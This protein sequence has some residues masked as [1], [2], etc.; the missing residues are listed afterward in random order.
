M[1]IISI[2]III[3]ARGV[4]ENELQIYQEIVKSASNAIFYKDLNSTYLM[5]NEK[6]LE[7]FGRSREEVI[8]KN[9][10]EI[11]CEEEARRNIRDDKIVFKTGKRRTI[12]K[13]MTCPEG[14]PYWF[15]AIKAP[16]YDRKG[17]IAG[18]FGIARDVTAQTLSQNKLE[19]S[20]KRYKHL[21]ETSPCSIMLLNPHGTIVYCNSTTTTMLGYEKSELIGTKRLNLTVK[22]EERLPYLR[23]RMKKLFEEKDPGPDIHQL[24]RKDG[25][26]IWVNALTS[27]I[28]FND[29]TLIQIISEDITE[30]KKAQELIKE[31][32]RKLKELEQMRKDLISRISHE[33]KTPLVSIKGVTELIM[34]IYQDKLDKKD[35]DLLEI[36]E[37]G[38][39]RLEQLIENLIDISRIEYKELTL[40]KQSTDLCHLIRECSAMIDHLLLSKN[41]SLHVM[42]PEILILHIDP[43][44]IEQVISNLLLNAI[45][46][47]PSQGEITITGKKSNSHIEISIHDSG[48]GLTLKEKER[49]F[50]RFGKIER[51]EK[52]LEEINIQGVG[53]GLYICKNIIKMHGGKIWAESEGRHKGS[54]FTF[55]LPK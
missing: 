46:H 41:L 19:K 51:Y 25:T 45:K 28:Q 23:E 24:R 32:N 29:K 11:M 16:Y 39:N 34:Q 12:T 44:R 33:L 38:E 30:K 50:T 15:E 2:E 22:G 1:L 42:L 18:L 37:K 35:M 53:L 10:V 21:F 54:T 31:E 13:Q 36:L 17:A 26:I 6:T 52:G 47:T 27:M 3:F 55:S 48:V 4:K 40:K 8:G 9:D 14:E 5:V 49:L 20:E 43:I 7:V